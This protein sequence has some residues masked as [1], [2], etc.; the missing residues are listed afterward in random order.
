MNEKEV[1]VFIFEKKICG[2]VIKG[3]EPLFVSE[4]FEILKGRITENAKSTS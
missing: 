3:T 2:L 1:E 4:N